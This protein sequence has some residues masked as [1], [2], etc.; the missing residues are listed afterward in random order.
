MRDLYRSPKFA[1]IYYP[2]EKDELLNLLNKYF[3][4]SYFDPKFKCEKLFKTKIFGFVVPHAA[5]EF[6]GSIAAQAYYQIADQDIDTFIIIAPD[7]HGIGNKISIQT[8]GMWETPLG[9][10]KIN[11]GVA[12]K[13]RMNSNKIDVNVI[14]HNLEHSIEIQLPFIQFYRKNQFTIVPILVRDQSVETIRELG[15]SIAV[16]TNGENV[17]TIATSDFTHYESNDIAYIKDKELIKTIV[18]LDIDSFFRTIKDMNISICGYGPI[19]ALLKA[20]KMQGA[21]KG[22]LLKYA[23][24][25]EIQLDF[26]NTVVGYCAIA[27]T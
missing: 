19:A 27:F 7:H 6:S 18:N 23:T 10:I 4:K 12:S 3:Y 2:S 22:T 24:S 14:A 21:E 1:G 20:I 26:K 5:Y 11:S 25:G 8:D 16:S 9:I 13:I 17:I 15:R